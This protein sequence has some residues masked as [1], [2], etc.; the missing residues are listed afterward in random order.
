M[1]RQRPGSD[2]AL[3]D[4]YGSSVIDAGDV[5]SVTSTTLNNNARVDV[6][7]VVGGDFAVGVKVNDASKSRDENLRFSS[8]TEARIHQRR[9]RIIRED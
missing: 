3:G 7:K 6:L 8:G 1:L 4:S 9:S 2:D 5:G